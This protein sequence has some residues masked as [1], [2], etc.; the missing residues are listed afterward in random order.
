MKS[1]LYS[2]ML[3]CALAAALMG[4][5][6]GER[7]GQQDRIKSTTAKLGLTAEQQSQSTAIFSDA[8]A[9]ESA[10][11]ASL[12]TAHQALNDAVKSNDTVGIEQRS[13]TLG[14]LTAQLTLAQSKA[15]SAVR[16]TGQ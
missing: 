4:H 14:N 8:Q 16:A 2:L 12:K 10:L 3:S 6:A 15:R 11:R 5:A 1:M 9:T 7:H 13:S